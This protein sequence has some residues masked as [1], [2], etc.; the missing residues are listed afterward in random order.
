MRNSADGGVEAAECVL[1]ALKDYDTRVTIDLEIPRFDRANHPRLYDPAEVS[2]LVYTLAKSVSLDYKPSGGARGVDGGAKVKVLFVDDEAASAA[3][4]QWSDPAEL[5]ELVAK[6]QGKYDAA[7]AGEDEGGSGSGSG[8]KPL[9]IAVT[10]TADIKAAGLLE[11]LDSAPSSLSAD[12]VELVD[13]RMEGIVEEDDSAFI[14]VTP[15]LG[16]EMVGMRALIRWVGGWVRAEAI[17]G[18]APPTPGRV[19]LHV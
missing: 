18:V 19:R 3:Q 12:S 6:I 10:D 9:T 16:I 17:R 5:A 8:G 13:E 15:S 7:A 2:Q 11:S 14:I 4:A 1:A